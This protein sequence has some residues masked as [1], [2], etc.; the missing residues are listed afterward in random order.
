MD[1]VVSSQ[2][3]LAGCIQKWLEHEQ[4]DIEAPVQLGIPPDPSPQRERLQEPQKQGAI[5]SQK[6]IVV[7]G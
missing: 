6:R 3:L 5:L 1:L 4:T 2:P 7:W